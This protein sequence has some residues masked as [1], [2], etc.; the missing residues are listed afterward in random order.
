MK[1]LLVLPALTLALSFTPANAGLK[2]WL[3][4]KFFI[5]KIEDSHVVYGK[6]S[7]GALDPNHVKVFVWNIYKA[8]KKGF[9]V[10]FA[11]HARGSDIFM[12]QE[13]VVNDDMQTALGLFPGHRF[14]MGISFINKSKKG[15]LATGTVIGSN[16]DPNYVL[17]ERTKD[18]E[19]VIKT[20]KANTVGYYPIEGTDKELLIVNIHGMNMAGDEAFARHVDQC[21]EHIKNHDG[22][23]IFAGDFNS[24]ND[25]R[26]NHMVSGMHKT[27]MVP[28]LFRDDKRRKSKF[29]RAI[30]DYSFVR[31]LK[32]KD[33]WVLG[34]L[35]TSDHKAMVFEAEITDL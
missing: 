23:A 25:I 26:I 31:G 10:D 35:K 29:S 2:S 30:I 8:S 9:L 1:T 34:K 33:A 6:S 14:D 22:P 20:P 19:P 5:P 3:K 11:R 27:G 7:K 4:K 24:K 12:L 32:I 28:V 13:G 17:I 15:D 21:L 16:V 18:L